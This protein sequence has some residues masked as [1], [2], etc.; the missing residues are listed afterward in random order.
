MQNDEGTSSRRPEDQLPQV[1]PAIPAPGEAGGFHIR[2]WWRNG[3]ASRVM[4]LLSV[5]AFMHLFGPWTPAYAGAG[6]SQTF[7]GWRTY[8]PGTKTSGT[9]TAFSEGQGWPSLACIVA[10]LY[11]LGRPRET[12]RNARW[13]PAGAA[14]MVFIIVGLGLQRQKAETEKWLEG[15]GTRPFVTYSGS[16]GAVMFASA[17][18]AVCGAFFARGCRRA[19]SAT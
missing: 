7:D 16:I 4:I 13:V 11:V 15:F 18:I 6:Y 2:N 14:V 17:V 8:H 9:G 19:G 5:F 1:S 10:I 3:I 12:I